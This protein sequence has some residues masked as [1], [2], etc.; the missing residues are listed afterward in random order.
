M[1][2]LGISKKQVED[3]LRYYI[4]EIEKIMSFFEGDPPKVPR[5][6]VPA[7]QAALKKLKSSLKSEYDMRKTQRARALMTDVEEAFYVHAVLEAMNDIKVKTN[8]R[9]GQQWLDDLYAAQGSLEYYLNQ[10]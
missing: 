1:T 8:S 3:A 10:L 9:P 2:E 7:A 6:R 4:D 5:D